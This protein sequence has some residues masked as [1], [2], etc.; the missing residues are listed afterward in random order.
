[1]GGKKVFLVLSFN[2][3]AQ[4]TSLTQL[5]YSLSGTTYPINL[6]TGISS[7]V[8]TMS[9]FAIPLLSHN[10][11]DT[12]ILR[13]NL[14]YKEDGTMKRNIT[15]SLDGDLIRKVRVISARKMISVSQLL[16]NEVTRIIEENE[17]YEEN[18]KLAL[19]L[20]DTGYHLGG[21]ITVMR[22]ELHER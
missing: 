22:E 5:F 12:L 17:G 14:K 16:S 18:R 7:I 8:W 2:S 9:L 20:L 1:M 4:L 13:D 6:K 21:A 19:S 10:L 3:P 11:R 15:L